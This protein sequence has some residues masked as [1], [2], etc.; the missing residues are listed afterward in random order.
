MSIC[1]LAQFPPPIHG[2]SKAVATLFQSELNYKYKFCKINITDNRRILLTL[3][4]IIRSKAC[5][6]YFTISQSRGGNLRDLVFLTLVRL[7]N[8][9]CIIHLHGGYYKSLMQNDCGTIQRWINR[10]LMNHVDKAIVLGNSL[11]NM[12]EGFVPQE[13]IRVVPNCIDDEFLPSKIS[14]KLTSLHEP[15]A[16]H[17]VY[18]SNFI[19]EKGY[20]EVLELAR[21]MQNKNRGK[22]FVFHFAGKFFN[23]EEQSFFENYIK[24]LHLVNIEYHGVVMAE[25][26]QNLLKVGNVMILLSRYPNEGQPISLLEG[27]G[28]GM[29]IVTTNHSGIPDI[30]TEKNGLICD[31]HH[32]DVGEITEYLEKCWSDRD[33]LSDVCE[34]NFLW[35]KDNFTQERYIEN[36]DK[37][38]EEVCNE[39]A[40]D[41]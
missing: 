21:V 7:K 32:I 30:V 6:F 2:L 19:K 37:V 10:K 33:Y 17:V 34:N 39:K 13:R 26:K 8:R 31:K 20:R 40:K 36:M 22:N 25:E 9:K 27:M 15:S 14:A 3:I 28:N 23:K 1:F 5:I 11:R 18:L 24:E 41:I 12:F 4:T 29:A 16:I 35:V 38:F